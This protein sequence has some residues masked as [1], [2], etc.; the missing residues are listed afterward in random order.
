MAKMLMGQINHARERIKALTVEKL[1]KA[2]EV[3]QLPTEKDFKKGLKDGSIS[4]SPTFVTEAIGNWTAAMPRTEIKTS[5]GS[6]NYRTQGY[7]PGSCSI[8]STC[9]GDL[10]DYLAYTWFQNT[11]EALVAEWK[12]DNTEYKRRE[13]IIKKEAGRVEDAIVLGDHAAALAAL[14]RFADFTV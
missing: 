6:W 2:P 11:H 14:E 8:K 9:G 10:G 13:K 12:A 3:P 7:N 1:G 4:L 5:S